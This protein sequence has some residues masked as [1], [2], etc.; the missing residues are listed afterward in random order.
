MAKKKSKKGMGF[1]AAAR[2][3]AKGYGG[4]L[5][6]GA[7]AVAA[8]SRRASPEAKRRNPNLKKVKGAAKKAPAKKGGR[9]RR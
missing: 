6:R 5:E 9:G 2:E 4:N 1:K 3:A 8:S 7:A